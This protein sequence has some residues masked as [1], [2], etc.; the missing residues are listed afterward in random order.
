[1]GIFASGSG[2]IGVALGIERNGVAF[3]EGLAESKH[4]LKGT[5]AYRYLADK[6]REHIDTFQRML[7]SLKGD[8]LPEEVTDEYQDYLKALV[9]SSVFTDDQVARDTALKVSSD[10][11]AIQIGIGTE[12]D[13]ILFYS[14]LRGL[15]RRPDRDTL[16]R[17]ISEEKSHL[18][19]LRDMKSDLAR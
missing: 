19:Q 16:D 7:G 4:G 8:H 5:S 10:A 15:V 12:K 18:R 2:L 3:Y 9:D 17:I 6:E 11:E 1:M 13:S 14:E